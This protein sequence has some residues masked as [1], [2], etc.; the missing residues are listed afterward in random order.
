MQTETLVG[1]ISGLGGAVIGAGGALLGG[2]LQQRHQAK[3]AKQQRREERRFTAGRTALDMLIRL[4][5]VAA[6]RAEGDDESEAAWVDGLVEWTT[7]F[8]AALLVV[9]DG[10]EMRE[11]V[12]EVVRHL[13]FY[14]SLGQT[15][16][17]ASGWIDA[18]CLEGIELLSAFLREEPLPA[19]SRPFRDRTGMIEA[20]L[21]ARRDPS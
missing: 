12:F 18:T 9:P 10:K 4:R 11:R 19:Q 13:G 8:D 16:S 1:L 2:W 14:E 15:H 3:T 7:T 6:N 5:H 17:E 21:R 20:H